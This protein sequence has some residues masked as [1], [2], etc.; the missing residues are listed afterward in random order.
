MGG[1]AYGVLE[2]GA[3]ISGPAGSTEGGADI[4]LLNCLLQHLG[5]TQERTGGASKLATQRDQQ[6]G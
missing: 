1:A 2:E 3:L 5:Q 6:V 4:G